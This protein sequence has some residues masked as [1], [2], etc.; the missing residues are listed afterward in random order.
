MKYIIEMIADFLF[1]QKRRKIWH[2]IVSFMAAIVVF[3]TT[4]AL[5]L[6]AITLE[7]QLICTIDDI[8]H[9]HDETCYA[10]SQ[11]EEVTQRIYTYEGETTTVKVTLP[12]DSTVPEDAVLNVTPIVDT[13][14][15]YAELTQKA[16]ETMEGQSCEVVLFDIS[17]YTAENEYIPVSEE[18]MVSFEFKE[19]ILPEGEGDVTILHYEDETQE[20]VALENV[21]V[22]TDENE[23]TTAVTFQTEGFSVFAMVKV[24]PQSYSSSLNLVDLGDSFNINDLHGKRYVIVNYTQERMLSNLDDNEYSTRRLDVPFSNVIGGGEDP[25]FWTFEGVN[26]EYTLRSGK[27]YLKADGE[28]LTVVTSSDE[29]SVFI[30]TKNTDKD[31]LFLT[32]G[33]NINLFGGANNPHGFALW[34]SKDAGSQL[35]LYTDGK[36]EFTP[37]TGLEGRSYVIINFDWTNRD[38]TAAIQSTQIT[39]DGENRLAAKEIALSEIIEKNPANGDYQFV[40]NSDDDS[41]YWTFEGTDTV[42]AYYIKDT[43]GKYINIEADYN[44]TLSETPQKIYV[45]SHEAFGKFFLKN[46]EG[47]RINLADFNDRSKGFEV[48]DFSESYDF[49]LAE[50]L[51][52]PF[53]NYLVNSGA[54]HAVTN[55]NAWVGERPSVAS[56]Q[57]VSTEGTNLLSV[58]GTK[59]DNGYFVYCEHIA[60]TADVTKSE[61]AHVHKYLKDQGKSYGKEF[62]FIGWTATIDGT[63]VLFP[64]NAEA[65]YKDGS[66]VVTDV[67][68][69]ERNVPIGTTLK[70]K[71]KQI[72]DTVM[73]FV[74]YSGTILDTEGNVS[75]RNQK[76]F[77][78]CV[79]IAR[80]YFGVN[81]VGDDNLFA[82]ETDTTIDSFFVKSY[83]PNNPNTQIVM[84]Y[85]AEAEQKDDYKFN[86]TAPGINN[87]EL[88]TAVLDYI[89]IHEE[90]IKLSTADNKNN[91]T[92]DPKNATGEHYE[93]RWYVMKEQTDAWHIDGVLVAKTQPIEVI[94]TFSGLTTEQTAAIIGTTENP[95]F[96]VNTKVKVGENIQDYITINAK[97]IAGQFEY[98]GKAADANSYS[99]TFNMVLDEKYV[100]EETDYAVSG[101]DCSTIV[102]VR[103]K[104]G[105][106]HEAYGATSTEAITSIG[107][108]LVGG[109]AESVSFNNFYTPEGTGAFSITKRDST[110]E[111]NDP[112]GK[113]KNAKFVLKKYDEETKVVGEQVGELESN[114]NGAVSF[115]NIPVGTYILEESVA[116]TGYV[117]SDTKWIVKVIKETVVVDGLETYP[118]TVKIKEDKTDAVEK[119]VYDKGVMQPNSTIIV[120]NKPDKGTVTITKRFE[121]LSE[122]NIKAMLED[123]TKP[124]TITMSKEGGNTY[125]LNYENKATISTDGKSLTW[126]LTEVPSGSYTVV[127]SNF[128]HISSKDTIVNSSTSNIITVDY[129]AQTAQFNVEIEEQETT[130]ISIINN[131]TN[132]FTLRVLKQ[133]T[134]AQ[135]LKG[136][137]FD[138]YGAY[139]DSKDTSRFVTYKEPGDSTTSTAYYIGTMSTTDENGIGSLVGL[140]LSTTDVSKTYVLKEITAPD[141]YALL[142]EPI[143]VKNAGPNTTAVVS[144]SGAT[145]IYNNG[146]F[147]VT[148][149]NESLEQ[150]KTSVVVDKK[151]MG[152]SDSGPEIQLQLWRKIPDRNPERVG[153]AIAINGS[154]MTPWQHEWTDLNRYDSSG[155]EYTYFVEEIPMD[156]YTTF[157]SGDAISF[158]DLG[159]NRTAGKATWNLLKL[160]YEL[161]I[162]NSSSYELPETGGSGT[163]M[164]TIGGLVLVLLGA[165]LY[166]KKRTEVRCAD[167]S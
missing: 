139:A 113:L 64:E 26:G 159:T 24:L 101:Y 2:K 74:N 70:G 167:D 12:L 155:K 42:G 37:V 76:E 35:K 7:K 44:L 160:K 53:I 107:E 134:S 165:F 91:P 41:I 100:M 14:D 78:P 109:Y 92:I 80:V 85:V 87:A 128:R 16:E 52:E 149:A 81:Q 8:E 121:N 4:Y 129:G 135:P 60:G 45:V 99:W 6:P 55:V 124:Y 150:A 40:I 141:G 5:I 77:T 34:G 84:E 88:M 23:E 145:G 157:Y 59:N 132:Q 118:I 106:Y 116:P 32:S 112:A 75:G 51:S 144:G 71:W 68:G 18:A 130:N 86:K 133:N 152:V 83:D 114:V 29:A 123:G 151:W 30:V 31:A 11:Q 21:K 46:E 125:T 22:E 158:T 10:T 36:P 119:T 65:I 138:V 9:V 94:K 142:K 98:H 95:K 164:Y 56:R 66:I 19:N 140:E 102:V 162:T 161:T 13:D 115:V 39:V 57:E 25:V 47:L 126:H 153:T 93:V 148:V 120:M 1:R 82:T 96:G 131:Y 17:F 33:N 28:Q 49:V 143:V 104:D 147:D 20:P 63:E 89:R 48:R 43:T 163:Q 127:E 146:N 69:I 50:R 90:V 61:I 72:S 122:A 97:S 105:N 73:F 137:V 156:G 154:E 38:R 108:Y 58:E 62:K 166:R 111:L 3:C 15:T 103:T 117:K 136:A 110:L 27:Q 54:G 79:G 67:N